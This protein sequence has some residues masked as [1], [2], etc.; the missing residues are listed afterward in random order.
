[1]LGIFAL[2]VQAGLL[3]KIAIVIYQAQLTYAGTR[4]SLTYIY[5]A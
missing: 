3:K 1:M 4:S 2:Q 5:L